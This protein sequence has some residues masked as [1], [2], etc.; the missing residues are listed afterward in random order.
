M[1]LLFIF[2]SLVSSSD[3]ADIGRVIKVLGD[4]SAYLMRN[5]D[6]RDLAAE[7]V[8]EQGDEIHSEKSYIVLQLYPSTQMIRDLKTE[9]VC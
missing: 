6:K 7:M 5:N 1:K 2:L 4:S 8:L 9:L 3:F